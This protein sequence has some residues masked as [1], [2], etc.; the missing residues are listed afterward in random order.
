[1]DCDGCRID[2][3]SCPDDVHGDEF[4]RQALAERDRQE[5]NRQEYERKHGLNGY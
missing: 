5:K 4:D 2:C 1:M 3:D